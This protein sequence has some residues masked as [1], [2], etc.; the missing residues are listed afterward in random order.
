VLPCFKSM[1]LYRIV[2]GKL[3]VPQFP[4]NRAEG[5]LGDGAEGKRVFANADPVFRTDIQE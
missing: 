4:K 3:S 2:A 1:G 5:C